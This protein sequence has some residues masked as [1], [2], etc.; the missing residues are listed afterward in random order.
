MIKLTVYPKGSIDPVDDE[1]AL[2]AVKQ[3]LERAGFT[4]KY[5]GNGVHMLDSNG[6]QI[7]MEK[8]R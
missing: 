5:V 6:D 3:E 7:W 1:V 8:E 2:H 4:T